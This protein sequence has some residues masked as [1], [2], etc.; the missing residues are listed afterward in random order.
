MPQTIKRQDFNQLQTPD[1]TVIIKLIL[2]CWKMV[3]LP[4]FAVYLFSRFIVSFGDVTDFITFSIVTI[5]GIL[6]I[7][8]EWSKEG[9]NITAK[10]KR[11]W[12]KFFYKK[13]KRPKR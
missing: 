3:G 13:K 9:D 8:T 12:R 2:A 4:A 11:T 7:A 1:R 5:T 10:I 6:K